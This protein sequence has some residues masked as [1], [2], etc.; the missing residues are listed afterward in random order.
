MYLHRSKQHRLVRKISQGWIR[1]F[2]IP[3]RSTA[4]SESD[5]D[6]SRFSSASFIDCTGRCFEKDPSLFPNMQDT[7]YKTS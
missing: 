3:I 5:N 6:G 4:G 7:A 2:P 1:G